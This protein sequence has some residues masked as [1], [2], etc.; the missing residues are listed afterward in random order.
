MSVEVRRSSISVAPSPARNFS[1]RLLALAARTECR[2]ANTE[3]EREAIF[4][5]RY[6]AYLREGAIS[7][8]PT[9]RFTDA[10]DS[11]D[12]AYLLGFYVDGELASSLRLHIGCQAHPDFPS[13]E[14]FPDVLQPRL[15]ARR[16]MVD[17]TRF[18]ADEKLSRI[19]RGLPYVTLR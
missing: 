1:E 6:L 13:L 19:H 14:V 9:R 17:S 15:D 16:I 10:D 4:R 5:L 7:A 3:E 11:D 8:N 12:N 2:A 18:V